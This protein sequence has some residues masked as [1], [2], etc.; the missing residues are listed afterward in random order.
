MGKK[1][2]STLTILPV[3]LVLV[4]IF[5]IIGIRSPLGQAIIQFP[6]ALLYPF[7]LRSDTK[8][9][10][11]SLSWNPN[12]TLYTFYGLIVMLTL[13]LASLVV[14]PYYLYH[15]NSSRWSL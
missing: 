8:Y 4:L 5:G 9:V 14:S 12:T 2:P 6:L 7:K 15:R 3:F 10:N 13:G 1:P 11:E